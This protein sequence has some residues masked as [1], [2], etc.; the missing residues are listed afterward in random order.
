MML[1][2][3]PMRLKSML[4]HSGSPLRSAVAYRVLTMPCPRSTPLRSAITLSIFALPLL[5]IA[6]L[7]HN[8][9]LLCHATA[10][11]NVTLP[12]PNHALPRLCLAVLYLT[13][14]KPNQSLQCRSESWDRSAS[15]LPCLPLFSLPWPHLSALIS[16]MPTLCPA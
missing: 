14:T 2:A 3:L 13:R 4:C 11:P 8:W 5:R 1:K 12:K 9:A 10:S 16:T 7:C 6:M 15:P